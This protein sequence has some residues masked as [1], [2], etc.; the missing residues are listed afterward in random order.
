MYQ[1]LAGLAYAH[2]RGVW[3][4][5]IKP[6]NVLIDPASGLVKVADWGL[7]RSTTPQLRAYTQEVG[8]AGIKPKPTQTSLC[9]CMCV[10]VRLTMTTA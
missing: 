5:D 8:L 2:A 7:A 3:H 1:V 4:R 6:A 9:V 10:C